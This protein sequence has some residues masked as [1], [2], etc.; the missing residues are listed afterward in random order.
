MAG[1]SKRSLVLL[2]GLAA[3]ALNK[4]TRWGLVSGTRQVWQGAGVALDERVR[5]ALAQAATQAQELAH[6]AAARGA[7]TLDTL[8]EETP[9]R[10]QS[11]LSSARSAA[12][13]L[14]QSAQER[15]ATLRGEAQ[16]IGGAQS[17]HA[18]RALIGARKSA[19]ETLDEVVKPALVQ[20]QGAGLGLLAEV[21]DRVQ[22]VLGES[23][24][25]LEGRRRQAE[26]LLGRARRSAERELRSAR[27]EWQPRKLEKA[28]DR[29]VAGLQK[30]LGRELKLLE[31]QARLARRDDRRGGRGGLG[32]GLLTVA[33]LG[34]G[35]VVLARVP[36]ARQGILSAVGGVSPEA[37][38]TLRRAGRNIR[39]IVGSVWMERLEEPKASP[40]AT[41]AGQT[42]SSY[43]ASPPQ[44]TPKGESNGSKEDSPKN[45][46]NDAGGKP[47]GQNQTPIN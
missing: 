23:A 35:A 9:A 47:G 20:A 13:E 6:E 5:P 27:K 1:V 8:R 44:A 2:G 11:L 22:D 7:S 16:E 40:A 37:A 18:R 46:A 36:A 33:L 34:G 32:G 45:T 25:T 26:K 12:G 38:E 43:G 24:D 42:G 19:G 14:A 28:I 31:K 17:E 15:A 39:N 29:K 21:K 10:A 4:D 30:D 3:L 41:A